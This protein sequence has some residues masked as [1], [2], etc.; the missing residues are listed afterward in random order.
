MDLVPLRYGTRK[1]FLRATK[2]TTRILHRTRARLGPGEQVVL[3]IRFP[4]LSVPV[5]VRAVVAAAG[6]GTAVIFR[7]LECDL[8]TWDHLRDVAAGRSTI[9]RHH[10]RYP[11]DVAIEC[12]SHDGRRIRARARDLS[13][14]GLAVDSHLAPEPGSRLRVAIGPLSDGSLHLAYGQVAWVRRASFGVRFQ[15]PTSPALRVA[16]RRASETGHLELVGT[17]H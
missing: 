12:R 7:P 8:E 5:L 17:I 4:G 2:T 15:G 16:L 14:R 3:D 1:E 11:A 9:T 13:I 6:T 10:V